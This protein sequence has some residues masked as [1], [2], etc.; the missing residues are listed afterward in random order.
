MIT[1]RVFGCRGLGLAFFAAEGA[2]TTCVLDHNHTALHAQDGSTIVSDE[3]EALLPVV[4]SGS[5]HYIAN[6]ERIGTGTL[7]SPEL[8]TSAPVR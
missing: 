5:T 8:P 3:D 6:G 7:P 4:V 1:S 2:V